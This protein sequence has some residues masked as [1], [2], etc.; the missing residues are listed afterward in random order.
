MDRA[1]RDYNVGTF[2]SVGM[3]LRRRLRELPCFR[4]LSLKFAFT[5]ASRNRV[6]LSLSL[7]GS[8][9]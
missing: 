5:L 6:P 3:P 8:L 1:R 4:Y 9:W 7:S 2:A